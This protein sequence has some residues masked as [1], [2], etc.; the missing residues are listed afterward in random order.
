MPS[1]IGGPAAPT[2]VAASAAQPLKN[3]RA[4]SF[5]P[6]GA[7]ATGPTA[8]LDLKQVPLGR[9]DFTFELQVT[10]LRDGKAA[11]P[12][13]RASRNELVELSPYLASAAVDPKFTR[14]GGASH[15]FYSRV[16]HAIADLDRGGPPR[17]GGWVG[18][19]FGD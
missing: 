12:P 17:R 2:H 11:G 10:P 8:R 19:I 9:R 13:R 6:G 14:Q 15:E 18:R 7:C 3:F 4:T 5:S 1:R 16:Q